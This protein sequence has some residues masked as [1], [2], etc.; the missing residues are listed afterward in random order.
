MFVRS[1]LARS[2]TRDLDF[3]ACNIVAIDVLRSA[4]NHRRRPLHEKNF[5]IVM[6][7]CYD[8]CTLILQLL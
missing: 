6:I 8:T 5:M 7:T 3:D 2:L 1:Y 4:A